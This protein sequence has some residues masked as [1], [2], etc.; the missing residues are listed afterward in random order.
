MKN[1]QLPMGNP[2]MTG[3]PGPYMAAPGTQPK[4]LN[5][6]DG[7]TKPV[8]EGVNV[9]GKTFATTGT[10][11]GSYQKS[12]I[13]PNMMVENMNGSTD[14]TVQENAAINA[15]VSNINMNETIT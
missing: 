4:E 1:S 10:Q 14:N 9:N 12:T 5:P 15:A 8:S 3:Y 7:N 2:D 11:G 13:P 6:A